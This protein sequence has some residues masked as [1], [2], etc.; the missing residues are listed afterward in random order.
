ML[1]KVKTLDGYKLNCIDGEI[2][3]VK[4]FYFDD[5]H[6]TI[7]YLI[8]DTGNW[9]TG[10]KVLISPYAMVSVNAPEQYITLNLTKK[11]IEDSPSLHSDEPV[12]RHFEKKY[13]GYYQWPIYWAGASMWGTSGHYP[14]IANDSKDENSEELTEVHEDKEKEWDQHLC[15][16]RDVTGYNIQATDGKIG[17]VTDFIIDDETLAI[18]YLV[19]NTSNW[20]SGKK[21]LISPKWISSVSWEDSKVFVGLELEEVK[22]SPEYTDM[23]LLNRDYED[24]LHNHYNRQGYWND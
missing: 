16:T 10:R 2:G 9:L 4:E 21:I 5:H 23:S 20:W 14:L 6:W 1:H 12:S 22:N 13:Y 11:Q 18:R 8:A 24:K 3:E 7:R 15:S 19:I 17:H